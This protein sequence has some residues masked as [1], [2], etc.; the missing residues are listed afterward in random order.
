MTAKELKDFIFENFYTRLGFA[1]ENS[2]YSIKH[3]KKKELHLFAA[4][5]RKKITDPSNA[6]ES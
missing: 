6:K 1:T 2:Y 3:Q 4:K 5:L